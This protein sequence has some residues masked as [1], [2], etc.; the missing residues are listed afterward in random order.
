MKKS[1]LRTALFIIGLMLVAIG[2]MELTKSLVV[3]IVMLSC[4]VGLIVYWRVASKDEGNPASYSVSQSPVPS[5]SNVIPAYYRNAIAINRINTPFSVSNFVVFDFETTGIDTKTCE[6]I[7]IGAYKVINGAISEAFNTL[8]KPTK[9]IPQDATRVNH[10][11]NEMVKTA[12]TIENIMP[13]FEA[14]IK[15]FPLMGYNI[16]RFD[17]PILIRYIKNTSELNIIDVYSLTT[18]LSVPS[19]SKKLVDVAAYFGVQVDNAHRALGDCV[20]TYNVF[21]ALVNWVMSK[22]YR[23]DDDVREISFEGTNFVVTGDFAM[24]TREKVERIIV[25][26][27]G[28]LKTG[29]SGKVDYLIVGALGSPNYATP[30]GAKVDKALEIQEKGGKV[31]IVN[32]DVFVRIVSDASMKKSPISSRQVQ[33]VPDSTQIPASAVTSVTGPQPSAKSSKPVA[34]TSA[35]QTPTLVAEPFNIDKSKPVTLEDKTKML[36]QLQ[37]MLGAGIITQEEFEARKKEILF[38]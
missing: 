18:S 6:I 37:K 1:G 17:I 22:T 31:K 32:E 8:I 23:S 24:I 27:G 11:T 7:E 25:N 35:L 33:Q 15:G 9:R 16:A 14:F 3:G 29:M 20:L 13:Q 21:N 10:I 26:W 12:P 30:Y 28:V 34:P 4:G 5:R 38:L 2:A 36:S 19:K